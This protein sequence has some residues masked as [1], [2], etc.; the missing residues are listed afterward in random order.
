MM[1][2]SSAQAGY[3]RP[4]SLQGVQPFLRPRAVKAYRF[5]V[6]HYVQHLARKAIGQSLLTTHLLPPSNNC[7]KSMHRLHLNRLPPEHQHIAR[8]SHPQPLL[9]VS[10]QVRR[11]LEGRNHIPASSPRLPPVDSLR[12]RPRCRL[13]QIKLISLRYPPL[14]LPQHGTMQLQ[15]LHALKRMRVPQAVCMVLISA[16]LLH[17]PPRL[18]LI[19]LL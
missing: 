18:P 5:K 14:F 8:R 13:S 11:D 1:R 2:R 12:A 4:P 6:L 16:C 9:P 7:A 3:S 19:L 10:R 17:G 15:H